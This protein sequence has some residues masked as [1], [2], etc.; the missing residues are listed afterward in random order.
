MRRSR[1]FGPVDVIDDY[2]RALARKLQRLLAPEA[3]AC[4]GHDGDFASQVS[5]E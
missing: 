1:R 4:A 2:P 5:H 3:A